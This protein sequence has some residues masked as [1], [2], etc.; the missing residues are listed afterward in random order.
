MTNDPVLKLNL[1]VRS[2]LAL[3]RIQSRRALSR[4]ILYITALLF[5]L[6]AGAMLNF[7]IYQAFIEKYSP[8]YSGIFVALINLVIAGII[9]F[10]AA[11]VGTNSNEEKM[12][13]EIRDLAYCELSSDVE[14]MK[15][16]MIIVSKDINKIRRGFISF[17]NTTGSIIQLLN[18]LTS[19]IGKKK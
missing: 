7:S 17:S 6:L 18:L 11:R 4:F 10:I 15:K 16:E 13:K 3:A 8:A 19:S 1:L 14:S 2:E 12:A 9:L 5:I